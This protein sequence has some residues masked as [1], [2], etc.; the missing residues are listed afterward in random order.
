MRR[1]NMTFRV[2]CGIG[3]FKSDFPIHHRN[4][5]VHEDKC[6]IFLFVNFVTFVNFVVKYK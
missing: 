6:L 5:K 1:L 2:G 3:R 4:T